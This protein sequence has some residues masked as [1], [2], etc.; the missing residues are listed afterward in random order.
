MRVVLWHGLADICLIA[1]TQKQI[2]AELQELHVEKQQ[3]SGLV[4][5]I[6]EGVRLEEIRYV[7]LHVDQASF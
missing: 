4:G 7:V 5:V 2:A 3:A 1:K 6:Q